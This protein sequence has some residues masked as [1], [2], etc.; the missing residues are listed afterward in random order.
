MTLF[1]R[2]LGD[3][4]PLVCVHGI[5][6]SS[7]YLVPLMRELASDFHVF[8]P[9]L[10]GSGRSPKPPRALDMAQLSDA[11]GAWLDEQRF[12]RPPLLGHS[13]GS[14]VV[15][16][17][18]DRSPDRVGPLVLVSPTVDPA[19]RDHLVW[20]TIRDAPR[21]P[22]SLLWIATVE[23]L[24]TGLLRFAATGRFA[25]ADRVEERLRRIEQRTLVVDGARDPIVTVP[26]SEQVARLLPHGRFAVVPD[27]AHGVP[28]GRPGELAALVRE[29]LV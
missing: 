23:F 19:T 21:E 25:L 1:F 17:L 18:A 16:E 7:R 12:D 10:P 5:G 2:E 20:A 3:G 11:L 29:F 15:S 6:M 14:Q 13:L 9:D 4:P 27:G 22:P 8:A 26:W 28:Y 24:R